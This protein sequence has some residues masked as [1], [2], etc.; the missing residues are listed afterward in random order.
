MRAAGL[1]VLAS[2]LGACELA[3]YRPELAPWKNVAAAPA[4]PAAEPEPVPAGSN[5]DPGQS[6]GEGC[7]G[8]CGEQCC[9]S[10]P[11]GLAGVVES[12][13]AGT[14]ELCKQELVDRDPSGWTYAFEEGAMLEVSND[15]GWG[16]IAGAISPVCA[17]GWTFGE[18]LTPDG[19]WTI[20]VSF[21]GSSSSI[22][23]YWD[24]MIEGRF[25]TACQI[26]WKGTITPS[27]P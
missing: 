14:E 8:T 3:E 9:W 7:A 15:L 27:C 6:A 12:Q 24:R 11:G 4:E 18:R 20:G 16:P 26:R 17:A 1:V 2:F 10:A 19:Q 22:D 23:V 25:D 5:L 13:V 21:A